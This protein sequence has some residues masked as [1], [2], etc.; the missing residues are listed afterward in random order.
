MVGGGEVGGK[1]TETLTS[2]D[3]KRGK[4]E[5]TNGE[6]RRQILGL[7]HEKGCLS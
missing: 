4:K 1:V 2:G 7:K 3:N 5:K 6:R